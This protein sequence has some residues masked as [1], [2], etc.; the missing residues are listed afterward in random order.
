[1]LSPPSLGEL[2][3]FCL[4]SSKLPAHAFV[5]TGLGL[6]CPPLGPTRPPALTMPALDRFLPKRKISG[7]M[8]SPDNFYHCH[9]AQH[10]RQ[11]AALRPGRPATAMKSNGP[12]APRWTRPLGAPRPAGKDAP[13]F[14]HQFRHTHAELKMPPQRKH[15]LADEQI[16]R[17]NEMD[18]R[19]LAAAWGPRCAIPPQFAPERS[20]KSTKGLPV[21]KH[22]PGSHCAMVEGPGR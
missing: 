9:S 5:V 21:R 7:R 4:T 22:W 19:D 3:G 12:G 17:P 13:C 10:Q 15:P 2:V 8:P 11:R 20:A 18:P 14:L 16:A 6:P 1:M